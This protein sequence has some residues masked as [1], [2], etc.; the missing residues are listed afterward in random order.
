[1]K[2]KSKFLSWSTGLDKGEIR[3]N[4]FKKGESFILEE[5]NPIYEVKFNK[6]EE[7]LFVLTYNKLKVYDL[8]TKKEHTV[9]KTFFNYSQMSGFQLSKHESQVLMWS[10][11]DI[12]LKELLYERRI[13]TFKHDDYSQVKG[14]IF[15][16]DNTSVISWTLSG[17]IKIWDKKGIELSRLQ[18]NKVEKVEYIKDYLVSWGGN[19]VKIWSKKGVLLNSLITDG[20][21]TELGR[22]QDKI[23][24][25]DLDGV[26]KLWNINNNLRSCI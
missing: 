26:V 8:N 12:Y 23:Y 1:M 7:K 5:N 18:H 21:I 10:D 3:I 24:T 4:S 9:Y 11:N 14:A 13:V 25:R 19:E 15:S 6:N 2:N 20:H 17:T 22:F 16:K